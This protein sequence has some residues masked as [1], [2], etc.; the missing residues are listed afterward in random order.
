MI[1]SKKKNFFKPVILK[2]R[3]CLGLVVTEEEEGRTGEEA[4][5]PMRERGSD[6]GA[7]VR[8]RRGG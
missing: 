2:M 7:N 5:L 4:Q 3:V 1:I 6:D 8:R